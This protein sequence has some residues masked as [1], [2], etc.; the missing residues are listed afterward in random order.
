MVDW[1]LTAC[2]CTDKLLELRQDYKRNQIPS[3]L[4]VPYDLLRPIVNQLCRTC[5]AAPS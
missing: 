4:G 3:Q 5:L 1:Q 2:L